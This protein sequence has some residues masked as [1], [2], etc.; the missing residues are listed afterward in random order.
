MNA[1]WAIEVR[2]RSVG[3]A[4]FVCP[5]CGVDRDGAE[6]QPQ[7]W[8]TVL[9]VPMLPLAMLERVIECDQCGYQCDLGVLEIPT[10]DVL[11]AY[12]SDAV[13]HSVATIV[14]AGGIPSAETRAAAVAAVRGEGQEYDDERFDQDLVGLDDIDTTDRLRRLDP[15]LTAHGKQGFLHRMAALAQ[16]D[17]QL[18]PAQRRALVEMGVALGMSAPHINGI[19]A[20]VDA[21]NV[22][23]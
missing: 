19:V 16:I 21:T 8:C 4:R 6:L 18:L 10:S 2:S 7:R 9:G 3:R 13:R 1:I 14:R 22:T 23:V 15:E 11:S 17:G 5:R 20:V 12:L